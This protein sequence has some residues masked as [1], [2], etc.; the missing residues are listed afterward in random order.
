MKRIIT[1]FAVTLLTFTC[2]FAVG[3]SSSSKNYKEARRNLLELGYNVALLDDLEEVGDLSSD[4]FDVLF[5]DEDYEILDVEY[6]EWYYDD[7]V[8]EYEAEFEK[9]LYAQMSTEF[10]FV[11]YFEDEEVA[12]SF[13]EDIEDLLEDISSFDYSQYVD[14]EASDNRIYGTEGKTVYFGTEQAYEDLQ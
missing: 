11:I 12:N 9:G 1:L 4:I 10:L 13:Y 7:I 3:C 2:L 5:T 6:E 14:Y 8:K